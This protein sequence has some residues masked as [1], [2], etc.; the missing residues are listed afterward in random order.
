VAITA[1]TGRA[2]T[3]SAVAGATRVAAGDHL[4][5]TAAVGGTLANAVDLPTFIL[6]FVTVPTV[7]GLTPR[8]TRTAGSPLIAPSDDTIAGEV[9]LQLEATSE[10]Q[11]VA[12]DLADQLVI[13]PSKLPIVQFRLKVSGAA[14]STRFIWGLASAYNATFDSVVSNVWF[15]LEGNSLALLVEGDDGTT[16][17]DDQAA[18]P[19]TTLTADTYYTFT[20]DFSRGLSAV[21]FYVNKQYVGAVS[22]PLLSASTL[23]QPFVAIQKS[24]GT[25]T[26]SMTVDYIRVMIPRQ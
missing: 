15:R 8:I 14:A 7:G 19:A 17:T 2:F 23:L 21:E 11:V 4:L 9:V 18:V 3:V 10:A 12:L 26:Q 25:G 24:T 1:K 20:I 5:I 22:V 13:D 16:D 6:T